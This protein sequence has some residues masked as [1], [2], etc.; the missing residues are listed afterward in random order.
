MSNINYNFKKNGYHIFSNVFSEQE[1]NLVINELYKI[2]D[3]KKK[4]NYFSQATHRIV[5]FDFDD[6]GYLSESIQGFTRQWNIKGLANSG[7][8]ILLGSKMHKLL[9]N[10]FPQFKDFVQ[11]NNMLFDKSMETID[12]IDS[13][14]LDTHPKGYLV[15]AWVALENIHP[16]AGPFRVYPGSHLDIDPYILQNMNHDDFIKEISNIKKVYKAKELILKKGDVV[17]WDSKLIHGASKIKNTS[18]SRKSLTA[19]YYP[20]NSTIQTKNVFSRQNRLYLAA[21]KIYQ[22]PELSKG[23]YIYQLNSKIVRIH[24]NLKL[25]LASFSKFSNKNSF[26]ISMDM[27]SK[28]YKKDFR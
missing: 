15:G 17:I 21:R 16:D 6:N 11:Q 26:E 10:I 4:P 28:S 23:N 7:N 8:N 3:K 25:Y 13:W 12:H 22:H 5:S 1:I 2:R 9:N 19:H 24:E 27:R 18:F 14:Y 20:I